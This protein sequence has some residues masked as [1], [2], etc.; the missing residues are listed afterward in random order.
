[1]TRAPHIT[2]NI[3]S[4]RPYLLRTKH[5]TLIKLSTLHKLMTPTKYRGY[6][7][8]VGKADATLRPARP[9]NLDRQ[10]GDR[11]KAPLKSP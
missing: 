8:K 9:A 5:Y 10:A 6:Q 3:L 11:T 7:P 4:R 1:M 2:N